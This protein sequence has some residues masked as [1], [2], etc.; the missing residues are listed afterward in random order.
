MDQKLFVR[1]FHIRYPKNIFAFWANRLRLLNICIKHILRRKKLAVDRLSQ[2]M[3]KNTHCSLY[4]LI[5]KLA[6][7]VSLYQNNDE[8]FE[9]SG[10]SD[11]RD[12]LI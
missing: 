7:K 2:V 1:F 11:Y 4:R 9:I 8:S 6:K 3:L 5:E 12:I 10:K